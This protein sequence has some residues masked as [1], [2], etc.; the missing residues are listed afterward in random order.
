MSDT[1]AKTVT[2][3]VEALTK[4]FDGISDKLAAHLEH[5]KV[6]TE[7]GYAK[8]VAG[9]TETLA[10]IRAAEGV[11]GKIDAVVMKNPKVALGAAIIGGAIAAKILS[12]GKSAEQER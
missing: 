4:V 2:N 3:S 5:A 1:T 6:G 7:E 10:E 11:G 9:I 8:T 12:G